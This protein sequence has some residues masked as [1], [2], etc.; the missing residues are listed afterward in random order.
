MVDSYQEI[1]GKCTRSILAAKEILTVI[2]V[3]SAYPIASL[4]ATTVTRAQTGLMA[5]VNG[6]DETELTTTSPTSDEE[7]Q[8]WKV[9]GPNMEFVDKW[10]QTVTN[11]VNKYARSVRYE[12]KEDL[13]QECF[14][15]IFNKMDLI[16]NIETEQGEDATKKYVYTLCHNK[17]IDIMRATKGRNSEV[18]LDDKRNADEADSIPAPETEFDISEQTLDKAVEQLDTNQQ[19]VIRAHYF[20][21][22]SEVDI[23][24]SLGQTKWWVQQV[25]KDGISNLR[26]ILETGEV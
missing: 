6:V 16:T 4:F 25:K 18:S 10:G 5:I 17:I 22:Q 3:R 15:T 20:R 13:R 19:F 12:D 23:A 14:M 11:A 26:E 8:E 7:L 2:T 1:Q 24:S 9:K 21:G